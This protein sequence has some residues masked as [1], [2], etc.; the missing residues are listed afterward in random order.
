MFFLVSGAAEPVPLGER[1]A[2][3]PFPVCEIKRADGGDPHKHQNSGE[4]DD[5]NQGS[6]LVLP[7]RQQLGRQALTALLI[8]DL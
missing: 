4:Q 5:D 6:L 2:L 1:L 3:A 8:N 7:K